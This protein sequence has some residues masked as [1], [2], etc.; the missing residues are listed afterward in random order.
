MIR[1]VAQS[2]RT[3]RIR[4]TQP[5]RAITV[6][7]ES[8]GSA[9]AVDGS[10]EAPQ[11]ES[12]GSA[13]HRR[14]RNV[15][16]PQGCSRPKRR[17]T[18][19]LPS[20]YTVRF[21][22]QSVNTRRIRALLAQPRE[23]RSESN[24]FVIDCLVVRAFDAAMGA[25]L[26]FGFVLALTFACL[27]SLHASASPGKAA[28]LR[29]AE[30]DASSIRALQAAYRSL[31][32]SELAAADSANSVNLDMAASGGGEEEKM[33]ADTDHG[34]ADELLTETGRELFGWQGVK[35]KF[36]NA[37]NRVR[38]S[39]DTVRNKVNTA[40]NKIANGARTSVQTVKNTVVTV[41]ND[42]NVKSAIAKA[43]RAAGEIA[44][45][46]VSTSGRDAL[47]NAREGFA[48][49]GVAGAAAAG[50]GTLL[51][52]A[53]AATLRRIQSRGAAPAA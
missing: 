31:L 23:V 48:S 26:R 9:T 27:S 51:R 4:F 3:I 52:G 46:A 45:E 2:T 34:G 12:S 38:N 29:A 47:V 40:T 7:G 49:G 15:A 10:F 30:I 24:K 18:A 28:R 14:R 22:I 42:P 36:N 53:E 32:E 6:S 33:A 25:L 43:G 1:R 50:G 35:D 44:K 16:V 41:A 19:S 17:L 39:V 37:R 8:S 5:L 11:N 20:I 13:T 21:R